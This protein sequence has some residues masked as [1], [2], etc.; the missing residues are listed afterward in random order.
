MPGLFFTNALMLAGMTALAIPVL[1]HLLLKR[2]KKRLR[3]STI[4]FFQRQDEQS[5]RRRKLRN[6]LLLTVRL[7]LVTLLVAAFAR[8][9]LRQSGA[10]VNAAQRQRVVFVLDSSASMLAVGTEGQRWTQAKERMKKIISSLNPDDRAALV[11]C[12]S[13]TE[14]ISGFAPPENIRQKL[15]ELQPTF[16]ASD[17]GDGLKQAVKLI[18]SGEG[19]VRETIYIVSD[20]Q[21]NACRGAS[22]C[23]VPE[24]V[25]VK[26]IA[27]GD[28]HSPNVAISQFEVEPHDGLRPQ[29]TL[30]SFSDEDSRN[31]NFTLSVDGKEVFSRMLELK[32]GS[33]TNVEVLFPQLKPGWHDATASIKTKDSFDVDNTRYAALQV[34]EPMRVLAVETRSGK[35]VFEEESF[36]LTSALDPARGTTNSGTGAFNLLAVPPEDLVGK[37]RPVQGQVPWDVVILPGLNNL[38]SGAVSALNEYVRAGGGLLFFLNDQVNANRYSLELSDLLPAQLGKIEMTPESGAGWRIGEYNTNSLVFAA[39]RLPNSGNL[40]I[41]EFTKRFSL[42]TAESATRVALFDDE[43]PLLLS[44]QVGPGRVVLVNTSADTAWSDWPKHKT[45][46]PWL[47]GLAKFL[48]SKPD[49]MANHGSKHFIAGEDFDFESGS[50]AAAKGSHFKLRSPAGN[51]VVVTCDDQGRLREMTLNAPGIYSLRNSSGNELR[52]FAVNIPAKE[53]DLEAIN[54]ADFQQQLTRS[55]EPGRQ[56]LAASLFGSHETEREFWTSLLGGALI[57]LL[58]EPLIANRTS[59]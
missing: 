52:R 54:P 55:E 32:A 25:D 53:S 44:R 51:E 30:T 3:F 46:V 23:T 42:T 11:L 18:S 50:A 27:L 20:F 35:H 37:L 5:S 26:P 49:A 10:S 47:H 36:F 43:V 48:S 57:L 28:L 39:F 6:W 7:L 31:V 33:S 15:T 24:E 29:A 41:P 56:T 58:L 19:H 9:Y 8:P 1:I 13:H 59:I 4:Q 45:F 21:K 40:R 22:G 14:V 38:P 17:I 16:G 12:A 34:P 2:K